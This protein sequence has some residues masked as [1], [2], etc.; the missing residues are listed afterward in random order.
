M[1]IKILNRNGMSI[2]KYEAYN[3]TVLVGTAGSG[4]TFTLTKYLE[5]ECAKKLLMASSDDCENEFLTVSN[6]DK[7]SYYDSYYNARWELNVSTTFNAGTVL[8][9]SKTLL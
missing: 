3:I 1:N 7:V 5:H 4:K 9:L 2:K 6:I 8:A